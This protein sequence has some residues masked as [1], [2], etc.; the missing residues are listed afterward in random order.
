M[1]ARSAA[2]KGA[3]LDFFRDGIYLLGARVAVQGSGYAISGSP[4]TSERSVESLIDRRYEDKLDRRSKMGRNLVDVLLVER[5]RDHGLDSA[6]LGR[7][8]L[9]LQSPDR[10]HKPDQR[11]LAGHRHVRSHGPP[12]DQRRERGDHRDPGARSVLRRRS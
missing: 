5:R 3:A 10:E 2:L 6:A 4:P 7:E 9:L 8:R 1:L 12:R 11:H